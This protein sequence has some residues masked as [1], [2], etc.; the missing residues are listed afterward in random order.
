MEVLVI[1]GLHGREPLGVDL[2]RLLNEQP[3]PN[4]DAMVGSPQAVAQGRRFLKTDLNRSFPGDINS[5][6]YET[7][8]AAELADLAKDYDVV[9]DF[10]NTGC[11]DNDCSFVGDTAASKLIDISAWLGLRR[12]IVA[13]Y[14]CINKYAP[15]CLSVEISLQSSAMD[16]RQWYGKIATLA[17]LGA[18]PSAVDVETYRFVKRM[19]VEDRDRLDL[20]DKELKAFQPIDET[21]AARLQVS[22]PAYP[23]FIADPLTPYNYGGLLN[24]L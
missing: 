24:K 19:T 20:P 2:V 21:L 7:R 23:I 14:D 17:G 6:D 16:A 1:G 12:V 4:V 18:V 9:L 11:T 22:S 3:L 10:H 8:R 15:N 13:D 5:D